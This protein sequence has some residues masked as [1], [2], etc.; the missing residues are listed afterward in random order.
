M[1]RRPSRY[2]KASIA[3]VLSASIAAN[4]RPPQSAF[5]RPISRHSAS[6]PDW[7]SAR[8]STGPAAGTNRR[9]TVCSTL[10]AR[11]AAAGSA[12]LAPLDIAPPRGLASYRAA[13]SSR[14]PPA[15]ARRAPF[16]RLA[17]CLISIFTNFFCMGVTLQVKRKH[18]RDVSQHSSVRGALTGPKRP[19]PPHHVGYAAA[20]SELPPASCFDTTRRA[21]YERHLQ[22]HL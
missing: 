10:S 17:S 4:S 16:R 15:S 11:A 9:S 12:P 20:H 19:A 3:P 6:K 7:F 1:T 2:S 21:A 8:A 13:S 5:T 14:A 18:L 22:Q